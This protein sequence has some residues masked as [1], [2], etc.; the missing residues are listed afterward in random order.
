MYRIV[1][2]GAAFCEK[3]SEKFAKRDKVFGAMLTGFPLATAAAAL[4]SFVRAH[5]VA[6]NLP[7]M[8]LTCGLAVGSVLADNIRFKFAFGTLAKQYSTA[9]TEMRQIEVLAASII[10]DN[11][12]KRNIAEYTTDS[13]QIEFDH[14]QGLR[15]RYL[16]AVSHFI[17][18]PF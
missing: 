10:D 17:H 15:N 2:S 18:L 14:I 12:N 7:L 8:V 9:A 3:E 4:A 1:G 11:T 13:A 6:P 5:T 16:A